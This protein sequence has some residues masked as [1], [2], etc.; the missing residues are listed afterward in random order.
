MVVQPFNATADRKILWMDEHQPSVVRTVHNDIVFDTTKLD[1]YATKHREAS[2]SAGVSLG[3]ESH[4]C[5][6]QHG[7]SFSRNF[8]VEV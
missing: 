4:V 5:F 7:G 1:K 2:V 8:T 6:R 3:W